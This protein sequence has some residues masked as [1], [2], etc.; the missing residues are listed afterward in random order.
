MNNDIQK[1]DNEDFEVLPLPFSLEEKN[2]ELIDATIFIWY[3]ESVEWKFIQLP[4][5]I[6]NV[7]MKFNF[8]K[9]EKEFNN[10]G[11]KGS[12]R[13]EEWKKREAEFAKREKK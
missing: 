5:T 13:E 6:H 2:Q 7:D 4:G 9:P 3:G 8:T 10:D 12:K 11:F 1:L